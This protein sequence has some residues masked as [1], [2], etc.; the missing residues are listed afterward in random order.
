MDQEQADMKSGNDP[1]DE[2]FQLYDYA[3]SLDE[4][5]SKC[6]T[7]Q[8]LCKIA[9]E[10]VQ[11]RLNTQVAFIFLFDKD[12][13]LTREAIMGFDK[14][15]D[16]IPEDWLFDAVKM[17][18]EHYVPGKS[19]TGKGIPP[20]GHTK[21]LGRPLYSN[22]LQK[23]YHKDR[24]YK[25]GTEYAEKLGKLKSGISIKLNGFHRAFGA[26]DV[27]NKIGQSGLT[28][29]TR[30]DAYYLNSVISS[31]IASH[32]SNIRRQHRKE[33]YK[34][35]TDWLFKSSTEPV[36]FKN[37]CIALAKQLI[38]DT[39]PF[40]ICIIRQL[41]DQNQLDNLAKEA[42]DDISW[43]GRTIGS[44]RSE[45]QNN[46]I[47]GKVFRENSSMY[48]ENIP[49]AIKKIDEG[50]VDYTFHNPEWMTSNKLKSMAIFPLHS[51]NKTV[52]VITLYSGYEYKFSEGN[53]YFLENISH[54][55]A[56]IYIVNKT[57][58]KLEAT[59]IS[60]IEEQHKLFS[61][62]R[63]IGHNSMIQNIL[64]EYKNELIEFSL[65]LSQLSDK[66]NLNV[67]SKEKLIRDKITWIEKRTS[68]I[69]QEFKSSSQ[70]P[71]LVDINKKVKE[72]ANLLLANE[73]NISLLEDFDQ[74]IVVVEIDE[75][76]ISAVIYNLI[77]NAIMAINEA[78]PT[79]KKLFLSTGLVSIKRIEYIE[80]LIRDNG[81]GIPNEI[82]HLVFSE[83]FSTRRKQGGTGMGLFIAKKV[84]DDFGGKIMYTSQVD[85]G[86]TFR[87]LIPYKRYLP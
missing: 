6:D 5:L 62:S 52:G 79:Q 73:Y 47:T 54:L 80:I 58:D 16:A 81:K 53:I 10:F 50:L 55:L 29:F 38:S 34:F 63:Q 32:I 15:G 69:N 27:I 2:L 33:I 65:V 49:D 22:N 8:D 18:A 24:E 57:R 78:N 51:G 61:E 14:N 70:E 41:N 4:L 56:S 67:N 86:T 9:V 40:K 25:Y 74:T 45:H 75:S 20:V 31:L 26:L 43:T 39:T 3:D 44:P 66:S 46:T 42:T 82:S 76:A 23:D 68:E 21:G 35:L 13:F 12:G 17:K 77:R 30:E 60:L 72:V 83:G 1:G 64:H 71:E 87:L 48:V 37:I 19:F 85:H 59:E 36:V 11:E 7:I 84:M 28:D